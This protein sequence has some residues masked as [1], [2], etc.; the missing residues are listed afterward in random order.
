MSEYQRL[1]PQVKALC[2]KYSIPYVQESVWVRLK[3]TVDVM[4]GNSSMPRQKS[5]SSNKRSKAKAQKTSSN[6]TISI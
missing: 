2:E 3:K 1:Q 6:E 5:V 4:V